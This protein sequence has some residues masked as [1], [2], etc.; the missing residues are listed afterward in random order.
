VPL[1]RLVKG[2]RQLSQYRDCT[3]F[4]ILSDNGWLRKLLCTESHRMTTM[5][6]YL[7]RMRWAVL[8]ACLLLSSQPNFSS[9]TKGRIK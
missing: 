4:A 6:E 9:N 2:V 1:R 3:S 7:K 5:T 8:A